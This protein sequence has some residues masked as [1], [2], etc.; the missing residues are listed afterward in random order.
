MENTKCDLVSPESALFCAHLSHFGML[1][2]CYQDKNFLISVHKM[3]TKS[4]LALQFFH[5]RVEEH[6]Q[7]C[8]RVVGN[9][10]R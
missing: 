4:V 1:W 10:R 9:T 2:K 5:Y 8:T 6:V 7:Y 3:I